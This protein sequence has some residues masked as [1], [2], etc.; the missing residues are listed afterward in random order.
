MVGTEP[1]TG[2]TTATNPAHPATFTVTLD[3]INFA[4][5]FH[6]LSIFIYVPALNIME[7]FTFPTFP[8]YANPVHFALFNNVS[9]ASELRRKLIGASQMTGEE[10]DKARQEVD[11]GFIDGSLVRPP[12]L[13]PIRYSV[14]L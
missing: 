14:G 4:G 6:Q 11:Y 13:Y 9:N 8:V 3:W 2:L 5:L 1:K 12:V 10:G 7:T